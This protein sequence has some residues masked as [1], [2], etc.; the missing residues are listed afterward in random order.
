[1]NAMMGDA[2]AASRTGANLNNPYYV[3]FFRGSQIPVPAKFFVL[4]HEH[5]DSINDGYFLNRWGEREW[6]D[7]PASF[8]GGAASFSFA[9]GHCELRRWQVPSTRQASR[10]DAA[11]LPLS[12]AELE[13]ADWRWVLQRM[14]VSTRAFAQGRPSP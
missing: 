8:H 6:I 9:D 5:P 12:L 1:M 4:V 14:S 13:T 2:G 7:L 11:P 10:P 3:Q